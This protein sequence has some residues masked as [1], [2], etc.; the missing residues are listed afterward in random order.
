MLRTST[1]ELDEGTVWYTIHEDK[2]KRTES[3]R[4][5]IT[6]LVRH[7][8]QWRHYP[9]QL[10]QTER[11][12]APL[13]LKEEGSDVIRWRWW[14]HLD[15]YSV[16]KQTLQTWASH[17][18]HRVT[19][20]AQVRDSQKEH[21]MKTIATALERRHKWQEVDVLGPLFEDWPVHSKQNKNNKHSKQN[22]NNKPKTSK[23]VKHAYRRQGSAC[24]QS[25]RKRVVLATSC[26][27]EKAS[28]RRLCPWT[29]RRTKPE[30]VDVHCPSCCHTES[31]A[32][33]TACLIGRDC[34]KLGATSNIIQQFSASCKFCYKPKLAFQE[35]WS[36]RVKLIVHVD[37]LN[38]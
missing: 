34:K 5:R 18:L 27:R 14:R 38:R 33:C 21:V 17:W 19:H 3:L 15:S 23:R 25:G 8:C 24:V 35:T 2:R 7:C 28:P 29:I 12:K 26:C 32:T 10:K 36:W 20:A 30:W 11:S 1:Y 9:L 13:K 31:S 6:W 37:W 22:T 16:R 4:L